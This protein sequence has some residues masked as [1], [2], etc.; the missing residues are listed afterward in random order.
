MKNTNMHY[1]KRK[2]TKIL[3]SIITLCICGIC[4]QSA[5]AIEYNTTTNEYKYFAEIAGRDIATHQAK[6]WSDDAQLIRITVP[7]STLVEREGKL[8]FYS[9]EFSYIYRSS[10]KY[11]DVLINLDEYEKGSSRTEEISRKD[12]E[13]LG[14]NKKTPLSDWKVTNQNAF[15][16]A[17]NSY[18]TLNS[19]KRCLLIEEM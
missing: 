5:T 9:T 17:L 18:N 6:N 10:D 3:L 7:N 13:K 19:Y 16:I 8:D 1:F 2:S 12:A 11:F 14:F 15:N 4:I